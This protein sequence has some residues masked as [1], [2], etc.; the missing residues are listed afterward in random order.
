MVYL[1]IPANFT[2]EEMMLQ[3]K[4]EKLKR[5]VF[6]LSPIP[7]IFNLKILCMFIWCLCNSA[8]MK[9]LLISNTAVLMKLLKNINYVLN[10][11]NGCRMKVI[12][13]QCL[14][15]NQNVRKKNTLDN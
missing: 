3:A 4:Y 12:W 6:A 1:H 11:I 2:E 15:N 14:K 8:T 13:T 10:N 5:K 7:L 9:V